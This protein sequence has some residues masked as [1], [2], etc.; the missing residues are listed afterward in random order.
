MSCPV[1]PLLSP[2]HVAC[3]RACMYVASHHVQGFLLLYPSELPVICLEAFNSRLMRFI[4]FV[5]LRTTNLISVSYVYVVVCSCLSVISLLSHPSPMTEHVCIGT[6]ASR[7][8]SDHTGRSIVLRTFVCRP[9]FTLS[10]LFVTPR[11]VLPCLN[12]TRRKGGSYLRNLVFVIRLASTRV[13]R[14]CCTCLLHRTGEGAMVLP[15]RPI[16]NQLTSRHWRYAEGRGWQRTEDASKSC[17]KARRM[18]V[19]VA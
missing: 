13:I 19:V 10:L 14:F 8:A 3:M 1:E 15:R 5:R 12:P 17:M 4:N 18:Y 7:Q 16:S 11:A 9:Y 2:V 6:I